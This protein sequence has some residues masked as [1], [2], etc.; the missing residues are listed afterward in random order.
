M[1]L[2]TPGS[3]LGMNVAGCSWDYPRREWPG[4]KTG[5]SGLCQCSVLGKIDQR[6]S[7]SL[8][9]GIKAELS[10]LCTSVQERLQVPDP[11]HQIR[12]LFPFLSL[13][14]RPLGQQ[15]SVLVLLY[16]RISIFSDTI[17][18]YFLIFFLIFIC[19]SKLCILCLMLVF[20]FFFSFIDIIKDCLFVSFILNFES[21]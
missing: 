10:G 14:P 12:V 13:A 4:V 3:A 1:D 18:H 9:S 16:S 6:K 2:G 11:C 7:C 17:K 21:E 19:K 8:Q 15:N 20:D 5:R